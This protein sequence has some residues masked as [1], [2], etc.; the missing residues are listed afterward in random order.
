MSNK[1]ERVSSNIRHS[2]V[3][4]LRNISNEKDISMSSIIRRG[5]REWLENYYNEMMEG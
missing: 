4:K 1:Y 3:S 2:D 5:V